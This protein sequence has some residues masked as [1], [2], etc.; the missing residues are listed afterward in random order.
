MNT[1]KHSGCWGVPAR[2]L[3]VALS[4]ASPRADYR[5]V[6]FPLQSLTRNATSDLLGNFGQKSP[7]IVLDTIEA[8]QPID[9]RGREGL[10]RSA[11]PN[12][13]TPLDQDLVATTRNALIDFF[14]TSTLSRSG[15]H[16]HP[17]PL[18]RKG[19]QSF[20][21]LASSRARNCVRFPLRGTERSSCGKTSPQRGEVLKGP[22]IEGQ[23]RVD[24]LS[25]I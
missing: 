13:S 1:V 8:H 3:A 17:A 7:L 18:L 16:Q 12:I 4:A 5:A 15:S 11:S 14:S 22:S 19:V 2:R 21:G 20:D 10:L 9:R 25:N 6:G 24:L 23:N